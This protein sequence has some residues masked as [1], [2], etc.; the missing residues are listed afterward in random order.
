M[1]IDLSGVRIANAREAVQSQPGE[2]QVRLSFEKASAT[3]LPF[4]DSSF[5]HVWSQATIYHIPDKAKVLGEAHRVLANGGAL[6][7]DDLIKPKPDVGQAVRTYVYDRL[8][9]D[10]NFSFDTYQDALRA[11]GFRVL[12][13]HDLSQHL[14]TSY[15]CLD[16]M[17]QE[18]DDGGSEKFQA[19]SFAY[20]QMAQAVDNG[21][22][23]WGLYICQK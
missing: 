19:L 3:Q 11:A 7:F 16:S 5:T 9:F 23:G 1:G 14:K 18:H 15:Q 22:L 4:D 21:E 2:V 12:E 8:L 20:Q 10:T 13:A 6:V 17:V